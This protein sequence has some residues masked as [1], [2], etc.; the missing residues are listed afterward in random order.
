MEKS[1]VLPYEM[2]AKLSNSKRDG[3]EPDPI[4]ELEAQLRNI[5]SNNSTDLHEKRM[6]YTQLLKKF[7]KSVQDERSDLVLPINNVNTPPQNTGNTNNS[8]TFTNNNILQNAFNSQSGTS[9]LINNNGVSNMDNVYNTLVNVLGKRSSKNAGTLYNYVKRLPQMSWDNDTGEVSLNGVSL[10][11][12]NI[13]DILSDLSKTIPKGT[14]Y[15][16]PPAG[17]YDV[18]KY[19][20]SVNIPKILVKNVSRFHHINTTGHKPTNQSLLNDQGNR[21]RKR[22]MSSPDIDQS[23][24]KSSRNC[25]QSAFK[26]EN[27][28][29]WLRYS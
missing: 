11:G 12:S 2:F 23:N 17:T 29:T 24:V 22:R 14:R 25:S 5:L 15:T 21:V 4:L 7:V 10:P 9:T 18:L 8:S 6:L 19:L 26:N 20:Q 13:I 27:T 1:V 3:I 16:V 28:S